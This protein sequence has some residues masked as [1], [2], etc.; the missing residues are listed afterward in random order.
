V[1]HEQLVFALDKAGW[2]FLS[3][4]SSTWVVIKRR[5]HLLA[6]DSLSTVAAKAV[7]TDERR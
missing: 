6:A 7:E 1:T 4:P 5:G 3:D 2:S